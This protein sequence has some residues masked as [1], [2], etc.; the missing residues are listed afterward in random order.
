MKKFI[1]LPM[2]IL[3]IGSVNAE[4]FELKI[5]IICGPSENML[6]VLRE[7]YEEQMIFMSPSKNETDEDLSHTLWLNPETTTWSFAVVNKQKKTA[8]VISSGDN[9][10]LFP[11]QGD[12]I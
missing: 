8:C 4:T 5:P 2:F 1:Y 10:Q 12:T 6:G 7:H 11:P 3:S 9:F